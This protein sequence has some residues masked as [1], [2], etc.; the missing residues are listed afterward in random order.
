M[1]RFVDFCDASVA[2]TNNVNYVFRENSR[3][4]NAEFYKI[5]KTS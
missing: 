3:K 1:D 5:K 4:M 2:C